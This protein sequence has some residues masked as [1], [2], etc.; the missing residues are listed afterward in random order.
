MKWMLFVGFWAWTLAAGAQELRCTISIN[1][2]QVQIQDRQIFKTME[3]AI[4]QFMNTTEWTKEKFKDEERIKCDFLITLG[5]NSTLN[6]YEAI[7]QI[8]SSRPVYGTDYESPMLNFLDSKWRFGYVEG[9]PLIF[10]ENTYTTEL[11][12]L[13]A[14]YAYIIIAMD[15]DSFGDKAG[16]PYYERALNILNNSQQGGGAGWNSLGDT[17]DRYWLLTNLNSPQFNDFREGLYLY[18]RQGLDQLDKKPEEARRKVLEALEK[19]QKSNASVSTSVVIN[20]FFL[21]KGIELANLYADGPQDVRER[22]VELLVL[23]DAP[24]SSRYRRLLRG[25]GG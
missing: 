14:F 11:T 23:L 6:N 18:H 2:E 3:T 7:V 13:M 1:A 20:S 21:T 25:G 12:S 5:R 19:M 8:K 15:F 4:T 17:R 16:N 24:N 22:A 9:D 10:A